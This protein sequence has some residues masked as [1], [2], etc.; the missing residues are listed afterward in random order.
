MMKKIAAL[1]LALMMMIPFAVAED[2]SEAAFTPSENVKVHLSMTGDMIDGFICVPEIKHNGTENLVIA[3]DSMHFE[4]GTTS[5]LFS[6]LNAGEAIVQL[7]H[8]RPS[9][10]FVTQQKVYLISV[11]EEG[12]VYV[13]DMSE[14]LPLVGTVKEVTEDGV[15][16]ETAD[17]GDVLCRLP[18]G[19]TAP[20]EGELIQ[21]W[22]N[23]AMTMSLP[24]QIGVLAWELVTMQPR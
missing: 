7:Q 14:E 9:D 11:S 18:E 4:N 20:M 15:M 13:R 17:Q 2:A 8:M 19:M 5:F 12:M 16:L 23:G 6:A 22:H 21:V 3:L 24:A 1:V 10:R